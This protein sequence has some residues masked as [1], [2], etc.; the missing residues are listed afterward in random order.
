ML[1]NGGKIKGLG[2]SNSQQW[3]GPDTLMSKMLENGGKIKGLGGSN[4]QQWSGPDTL[5]SDFGRHL[6][7][8]SRDATCG[9]N[10]TGNQTRIW[11]NKAVRTAD[12]KWRIRTSKIEKQ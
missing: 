5:M 6:S 12:K 3:S 2:G 9:A 4:S 8:G 1:G 7:R 11:G 10:K